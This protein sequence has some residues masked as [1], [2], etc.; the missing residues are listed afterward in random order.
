MKLRSVYGHSV[1][2]QQSKN[3]FGSQDR[4][5]TRISYSFERLLEFCYSKLLE[6]HCIPSK[7]ALAGFLSGP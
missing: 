6:G 1:L 7:L 3:Q 2:T 4:F 5:A